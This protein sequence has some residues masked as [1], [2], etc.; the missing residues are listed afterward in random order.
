MLKLIVK[1]VGI[2]MV[3]FRGRRERHIQYHT[4]IKV[5]A[6]ILND[7]LIVPYIIDGA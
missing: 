3:E 6:G 1:N 5:C 2:G 7:T 4:K